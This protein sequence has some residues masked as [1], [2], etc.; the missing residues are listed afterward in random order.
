ML[1]W[2][3]AY[4]LADFGLFTNLIT[5]LFMHKDRFQVYAQYANYFIKHIGSSMQHYVFK[6]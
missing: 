5:W 3:V 4:I 2:E 1:R 6:Q